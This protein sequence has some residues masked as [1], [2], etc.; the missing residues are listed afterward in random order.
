MSRAGGVPPPVEINGQ[1]GRTGIANRVENIVHKT[2]VLDQNGTGHLIEMQGAAIIGENA[3]GDAHSPARVGIDAIEGHRFPRKQPASHK[4]SLQLQRTGVELI[5]PD[6]QEGSPPVR[7]GPIPRQSPLI[8]QEA[9]S[10]HIGARPR[11]ELQRTEFL[12]RL[13]REIRTKRGTGSG[14]RRIPE[15]TGGVIEVHVQ[16]PKGCIV[17]PGASARTN[18]RLIIHTRNGRFHATQVHIGRELD[19]SPQE[20]PE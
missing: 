8:P 17:G 20:S 1:P 18:R 16:L 14:Q 2:V 13:R 9:A 6:R 4:R 7:G 19:P 15:H 11:N 12:G 3:I 10:G 5:V